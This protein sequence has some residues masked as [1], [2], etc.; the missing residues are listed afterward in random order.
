VAAKRGN[1]EGTIRQRSNGLWEGRLMIDGKRMSVYGDTRKDVATKIAHAIRDY[2]KGIPLNKPEQQ[3]FNEWCD[4]WLQRIKPTIR[5][6]TW[7]RYGEL[8]EHARKRLGKTALNRITAQQLEKLYADLMEDGLSSST[9]HHLHMALHRSLD[10]ALRKDVIQRNVTGLVNVPAIA[11]SEMHPLNREQAQ[12]F[13]VAIKG[14]YNEALYTL[15]I[16]T[17]MRA[18]EL[19]ALHWQ[20]VDLEGGTLLVRFSVRRQPEG[21]VFTEPKT[22]HGRRKIVLT[23]PVIEVLREHRVRQVAQR[24]TIGEAWQDYDLVFCGPTGSPAEGA[25]LSRAH[26]KRLLCKA[27]APDI[28]FHDLRHTAATLMLL[29]GVPTKVVSEML[30]HASIAI[31]LDTYS[32]VLPSM[33]HDAAAAME[34]VLWGRSKSWGTGW[35]TEAKTDEAAQDA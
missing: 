35:G 7:I 9:V 3:T 31:T 20:D 26:F 10:D 16:S 23:R 29:R 2:E 14:D 1:N 4:S 28:R 8:I 33:Q 5:Q 12:R 22:K 21:F 24:L 19:L 18:G 27:E 11:E 6:S 30:G 13:L 32:H 15:A 17:G 25:N 34:D